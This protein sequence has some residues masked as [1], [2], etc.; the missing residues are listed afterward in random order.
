M[1]LYVTPEFR[2][3]LI[4][5]AKVHGTI[6]RGAESLS[7]KTTGLPEATGRRELDKTFNPYTR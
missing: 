3:E 7:R 5:L 2:D 6:G 1:V 4:E